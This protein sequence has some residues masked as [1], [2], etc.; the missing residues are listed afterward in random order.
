MVLRSIEQVRRKSPRNSRNWRQIISARRFHVSLFFPALTFL[1][2]P[3]QCYFY[4]S[5]SVTSMYDSEID[6]EGET[7]DEAVHHGDNNADTI[8]ENE[9]VYGSD[10]D[11]E[12]ETD[13]EIVGVSENHTIS[14]ADKFAAQ[15]SDMDAEGDTDD[16]VLHPSGPNA[17]ASAEAQMVHVSR[18]DDIIDSYY[19]KLYPGGTDVIASPE[20]H[21][22]HNYSP[23]IISS[24]DVE[25]DGGSD[26]TDGNTGGNT[27]DESSIHALD[28]PWF[29]DMFD[30]TIDEQ[31]AAIRAIPPSLDV[32]ADIAAAKVEQERIEQHE[33]AEGAAAKV[34]KHNQLAEYKIAITQDK[35]PVTQERPNAEQSKVEEVLANARKIQ[36]DGAAADW[37]QVREEILD[38][39]AKEKVGDVS[40]EA[41]KIIQQRIHGT[42]QVHQSGAPV[43]PMSEYAKRLRTEF[44]KKMSGHKIID[45]EDTKTY[46][47]I[48]GG[49]RITPGLRSHR[50]QKAE[51]DVAM[52]DAQDNFDTADYWPSD[53]AEDIEEAPRRSREGINGTNAV[54]GLRR[55]E[56]VPQIPGPP[57]KD[58]LS[59]PVVRRTL[60]EPDWINPDPDN[61]A[62]SDQ[63]IRIIPASPPRPESW[64]VPRSRSALDTEMSQIYTEF[65]LSD[66]FL[67][68]INAML[69]H[70]HN[71]PFEDAEAI[72][73]SFVQDPDNEG[74]SIH[75]QEIRVESRH[76]VVHIHDPNASMYSSRLYPLSH[77]LPKNRRPQRLDWG[78]LEYGGL[79]PYC[80]ENGCDEG[81]PREK[82]A[83]EMQER[84]ERMQL[85]RRNEE[86]IN[87]MMGGFRTQSISMLLAKCKAERDRGLMPP[88]PRPVLKATSSGRDTETRISLLNTG[89]MDKIVK[90]STIYPASP[91]LGPKV[92]MSDNDE[93]E[94][95]EIAEE[96]GPADLDKLPPLPSGPPK[97]PRPKPRSLPILL[98]EAKELQRNIL[99]PSPILSPAILPKPALNDKNRRRSHPVT[100]FNTPLI[101]PDPPKSPRPTSLNLAIPP[102]PPKSPRPKAMALP[103]PAA[104]QDTQ[105]QPNSPASSLLSPSPS[106]QRRVLPPPHRK[107]IR[108][109]SRTLKPSYFSKRLAPPAP[110]PPSITSPPLSSPLS[111]PHTALQ[112]SRPGLSA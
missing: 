32:A 75:F 82:T 63:R 26:F 81:C 59:V 61:L 27:A 89:A 42:P 87:G 24:P 20:E 33:R 112:P 76:W 37:R 35:S 8:G 84:L 95:G 18:L 46:V 78:I 19:D 64:R 5:T 41:G 90:D 71:W 13:D 67:T 49:P 40:R 80:A 48:S 38:K 73:Q 54:P 31:I 39:V 56:N 110:A 102:I 79:P 108:L 98:E 109:P 3:I 97:S 105:L 17:I 44:Q 60:L 15:D 4:P 74:R 100:S 83:A 23:D 51:E 93:L 77:R 29:D 36:S 11:A 58:H 6:A 30:A 47:S 70:I 53:D 86:A 52:K 21:V 34:R 99:P 55:S 22:S 104:T 88:P 62:T 14:Q 69:D 43:H 107:Y 65:V 45:S 106:H 2:T 68:D 16:E 50:T 103:L 85:R 9:A 1:A 28:S 10:A 91:R 25:A 101:P 111:P 12:G 57:S 96:S 92:L 66:E 72:M 7:D 94:D